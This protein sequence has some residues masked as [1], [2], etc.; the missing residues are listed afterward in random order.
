MTDSPSGTAPSASRATPSSTSTS[1]AAD[2]AEVARLANLGAALSSPQGGSEPAAWQAIETA[3]KD[4]AWILGYGPEMIITDYPSVVFW[5]E[6]WQGANTTRAFR[7]T[8]WMPLPA[9]P[10]GVKTP[11]DA[12]G[13]KG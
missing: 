13:E 2:P 3:P 9:P 7:L 12:G 5:D 6:G 11:A 4:G 8:H 1:L 10:S